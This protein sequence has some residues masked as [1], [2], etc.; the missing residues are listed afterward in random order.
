MRDIAAVAA[1]RNDGYSDT[2]TSLFHEGYS[3]CL[4][5]V[6]INAFRPTNLIER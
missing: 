2:L 4:K 6:L 3:E 1:K 5:K